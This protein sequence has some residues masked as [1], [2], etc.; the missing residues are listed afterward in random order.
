M[1]NLALF[2]LDNTL[3]AGDSDK[4][5][6]QFLIDE[7]LLDAEES[8]VANDRFYQQYCD[9]SLNIDDYLAFA[10]A[11]LTQFSMEELAALH[12]KFMANYIRPMMSEKAKSL[13][14]RHLAAGDL[15]MIITATN[16]FV[17]E[18]IAKAFNVPYLIATEAEI[19][20]GRYTGKS[21]GVPSF[22]EGKITR[23]ESW[24]E[25]KNLSWSSFG[26]SWFYSDSMN[27]LPLLKLVNHPIAVDP[28][29]TLAEH[30][31]VHGWPVISLRS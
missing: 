22:K 1:K 7:G 23:L 26:E 30:A 20:D 28:D 6:N 31:E 19:K 15:V 27:D 9:G 13:V 10:L 18:P 11:P 25:E 17:T 8:K 24:L 5:W 14:E 12:E 3:L 4:T 2:D 29:A 16:R 21:T